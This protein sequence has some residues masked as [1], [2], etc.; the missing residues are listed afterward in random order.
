MIKTIIFDFG[1]VF[2]NLNIEAA[3]KHALEAFNIEALSDEMLGFNSFY[4]QGLISTEEFLDFYSQNFPKLSKQELI[5]IWNFMLKDFPESRLT[6]LKELK[7]S[8]KYKLILLSNTNEL[9]IDFI[10]TN[11]SF[12]NEFKNC[13]DAF[14]LSHEINLVKPNQDIFNFVLNENK[15]KAEECLFIDDNKDNIEA[16]NTLNI[17]TWLINP[18]T[19]DVKNLFTTKKDLF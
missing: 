15:L 10:K 18:E 5:D 13:F 6:F 4:E 16:A 11:V 14:Y 2:I 12:Y 19:E 8:S 3:H 17:K 9:H 7:Q 1:N